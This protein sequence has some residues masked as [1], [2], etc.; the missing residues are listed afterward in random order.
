MIEEPKSER[1]AAKAILVL[2]YG[3]AYWRC[4]HPLRKRLRDLHWKLQQR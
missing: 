3:V 4:W 2:L 1:E